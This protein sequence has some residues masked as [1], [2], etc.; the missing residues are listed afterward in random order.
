MNTVLEQMLLVQKPSFTDVVRRLIAD[1]C[2]STGV[3]LDIGCGAA[4][5]HDAY[6]NPVVGLDSDAP[7]KGAGFVRGTVEY[8]PLKAECIDFV[9]SFQTIYY[10]D[11]VR[12]ALLEM[13]RVA[14]EQATL[15]VSVSKPRAI[16]ATEAPSCRYQRHRARSW[17]QIFNDSGF[18]AQRLFP[19][20]EYRWSFATLR[21]R[22]L[23]AAFSPYFWFL[24]R[25]AR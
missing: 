23:H 3:S 2:P 19:L 6:V 18:L 5:Y 12:A 13:R 15:L 8:L 21:V 17:I 1:I 22:H 7:P 25:K 16:E 9:T 4:N 20:C 24:L 10:A 14:K 11:D